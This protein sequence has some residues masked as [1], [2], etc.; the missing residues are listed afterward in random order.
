MLQGPKG[1][2]PGQASTP[3]LAKV[4]GL[5]SQGGEKS[6]SYVKWIASSFPADVPIGSAAMVVS[7]LVDNWGHRFLYDFA[8]LKAA[9]RRRALRASL[10][11]RSGLVTIRRSTAWS[12]TWERAIWTK[13]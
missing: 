8:A 9:L 1:R 11:A 12:N 10:R 5:V 13:R 2:R 6:T 4:A 3:D 7:N